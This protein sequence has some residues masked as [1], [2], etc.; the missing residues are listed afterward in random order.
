MVFI[1]YGS[2]H[3]PGGSVMDLFILWLR[4]PYATRRTSNM[5][6]SVLG[7]LFPFS[8]TLVYFKILL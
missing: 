7:V 2:F 8:S 3:Q 1:V 4:E 6:C 5:G